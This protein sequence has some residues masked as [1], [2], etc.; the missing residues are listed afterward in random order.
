M[1]WLGLT[2]LVLIVLAYG[3]LVMAALTLLPPDEDDPTE[4]P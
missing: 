4:E 1:I 3:A 2:A